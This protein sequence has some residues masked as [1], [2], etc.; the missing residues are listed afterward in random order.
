M[1]IEKNEL[2]QLPSAGGGWDDGALKL[3]QLSVEYAPDG[4]FW[5]DREAR[6][7]HANEEACRSLGYTREEMTRL[8]LWDIDP[9][10]TKE[11]WSTIWSQSPGR[12]QVQARKLETLHRHKDGSTFPVEVSSKQICFEGGE[13]HVAFVRNISER[14]QVEEELKLTK[15]VIDRAS[16]ACAWVN[17]EGRFIY[18][19]DQE[20]QSLGYSREELL[21]SSVQDVVPELASEAWKTFWPEIREKRVL[22]FET[23]QQRKD[24][25]RFP[26]EITTHYVE[27]GGKAYCFA[28]KRD[29]TEWNAAKEAREKL[30]AQLAQAQKMESIGRLAGGVAHDFNNM[31]SVILGYVNMIKER[32]PPMDEC[33]GDLIQIEKA[34][35]R[36]RDLTRQLLAFSRQQIV[37]PVVINL[38]TLLGEVHKTLGRLIGEDVATE[39]VLGEGLWSVRMDPLQVDQVLVNLAVNARDAM[40][41]GGLLRLESDNVDIDAGFCAEPGGW[42][43]GPYV[44]LRVSD[45]GCGMDKETLAK[46]FDP[47]FTTKD[48]GKGTGLGLAIVYGIV[49]QNG[50]HIHAY[51]EVGLGTTFTIYLPRCLDGDFGLAPEPE[52]PAIPGT[53]TIL[54]VEDEELV[55][56]MVESMLRQLGYTV[57]AAGTAAEGLSLLEGSNGTVDL[58]LTDIVMPQMKGTELREQALSLC[59]GLKVLFMS[60]HT[61]EATARHHALAPGSPFIQKPFSLHDLS[62]KVRTALSEA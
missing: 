12:G 19:N 60:G 18:V 28:F 56:G 5:L 48:H 33:L 35:L 36:S 49:K 24:G 10:F 14:R 44:R 50:G 47:F 43:P 31:L 55:R 22:T 13:F 7:Y 26:V 23:V 17:A 20:C 62:I 46:C 25:H 2:S 37:A 29:L 8:Q 61:T 6:I 39:V 53:E 27:V 11:A 40:P 58:L 16:S 21:R 41:E 42:T 15:A 57:L 51:S 1:P 4:V 52:A 32:F 30:G 34:A 59:P 54:V 38:N 45:S 9:V 3:L